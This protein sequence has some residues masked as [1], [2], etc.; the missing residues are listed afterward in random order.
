MKANFSTLDNYSNKKSCIKYYD[1]IRCVQNRLSKSEIAQF[2]KVE[3]MSE[4]FDS[5]FQGRT[6]SIG[7]DR[8]YIF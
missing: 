7:S 8:L 3:S 4:R 6:G 2:L 5:L 1:N